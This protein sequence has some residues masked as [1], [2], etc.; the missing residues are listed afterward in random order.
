[1][2]NEYFKIVMIAHTLLHVGGELVYR[3]A[4]YISTLAAV[5]ASWKVAYIQ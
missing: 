1:M 3:M 2:K 5:M 4:G